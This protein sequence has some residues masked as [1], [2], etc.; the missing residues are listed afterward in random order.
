MAPRSGQKGARQVEAGTG[1]DRVMETL[2]PVKLSGG[3]SASALAEALRAS[4]AGGE[5]PAGRFLPALRELG[6]SHGVT[7]ETVR[8]GLK[9]LENE[10]LLVSVP[11]HGFRVTGRANDPTRGCPVGFVLS[12]QLAG[13]PLNEF[14]TRLMAELQAAAGR[15]GW[16]LLGIGSAGMPG[17]EV[18]RQCQASRT[19]G[20]I[21]DAHGAD[22]V[23]R[24]RAAG[25][26]VVMVDSWHPDAGVDAVV[27]DG[28]GGGFTA[29]RYLAERRCRRVA[30]FGP[31]CVTVHARSRFGGAVSGLQESGLSMPPEMI[32]DT[33]DED[34][35]ELARQL[36]SRSDRPDAVL[37][38]FPQ[39]LA[40][41]A[42][43]AIDLGLEPGRDLELVGWTAEE[44]DGSLLAAMP[45]GVV[46]ARINWSMRTL[47]DTALERLASLR[48]GPDRQETRIC[49]KTWLRRPPGVE[50]REGDES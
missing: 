46:P 29:A 41:I 30:W 43:A 13:E 6:R 16:S 45:R 44:L 50:K 14:H 4:L 26:G 48:R 49:V 17:A 19:W 9:L 40:E 31:A 20:L 34:T 37:A 39:K 22:I 23:R 15:R 42:Q 28:F 3:R 11:R 5:Y 8:R 18:I 25:L 38:L 2:P 27:Q 32:V 33:P 36:L 10:G 24:A 12:S 21:I 7:A 47:A 35:R 1:L